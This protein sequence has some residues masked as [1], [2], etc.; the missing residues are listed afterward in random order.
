MK[1]I[2]LFYII[3]LF[4]ISIYL[5]GFNILGNN[6]DPNL[7]QPPKQ[8]WDH[9]SGSMPGEV[10]VITDNSGFDNFDL[11]VD[12]SESHISSS[13]KNPNWYFVAYN[14]N[15][16]YYT[17]NGLD[18]QRNNPF[19]PNQAGDPVTAYDSLGNLYYDNMKSPITGTWNIKSTNGGVS[20][21]SPVSANIG[22]DKN[23]IAADQTNGPYSNYIYGV[24]TPGN[25]VR[26]TD[27]GASYNL[28]FSASNNLPGMMVAVG[29]NTVG[30]NVSGG[31]VYVVTNTG[32]SFAATY[33]FFRS[34]N[35]GQSFDFMSSQN[36][37]NY[38]G[39]AVNGRNSVQ[40]FRTRP[41]PFITA[42]NSFGPNRGRLYL[43]Y[44]SNTP[45]GDGNKPDIFCRY[46]TNHGT[47][48]SSEVRI[49]DDPNTVLHNQW[50]PS[51]WCDKETGR[52]YVQWNDTRDTPTS[53]SALV[54][55]SYSTDGGATFVQNKMISNKKFRINCTTCGG[56]GTPAYLG[57][58]SSITSNSVT[59]MLTWTD[60]RNNNFGSYVGYYPDFALKT[61]SQSISVNSGQNVTFRAIVPA[62]KDY[63]RVVKFTATM[64]T[65]PAAG[66]LN[67][68]FVGKDSVNSFPD[69]VS[70]NV[71]AVGSVTPGRYSIKVIG[72]GPNGT[73]I[74][75]RYVSVLVN[76]SFL[77]VGTNRPGTAEFS[78]NGIVYNQTQQLVFTNGASVN[79]TA[80]SPRVVGATQYVFTNWSNSGDT[81]QTI[82][83]NSNTNLTAFYKTQYRL[84]ITS[85]VGNTFG[86]GVYYDSASSPQIGVLSRVINSGG[87]NYYFRGWTGIGAGSYTSPDSTGL[88]SVITIN[89]ITVPIVETARWTTT[90]GINQLSSLV[91]DKFS[92]YQNYPNPFNPTTNIKFDII[93]SGGVK[94][95]VYNALGKEVNVLLNENLSP[96]TY[97]VDFDGAGFASGIYYYKIVTSE[98]TDVK[99]ML[100]IK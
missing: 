82:V 18:W 96:G 19:F 51:T 35:G 92:L 36:F 59:A 86:G 37:A 94:V 12:F 81:S 97:K 74:H 13:P 20:W 8:Y 46:S 89:N 42:D 24:M 53:D 62:V 33:S 65:L 99:K 22:N 64:D 29:A 43:V 87:T 41:Y 30:G 55:A 70:I 75:S 50:H 3:P 2:T 45:A 61:S 93:K 57:D 77:T 40:N 69:S 39:T 32:N 98:F 16:T 52:L 1:K 79:V 83:I 54:Y 90:V 10:T 67:I 27:G 78:V 31:C 14:T 23:W 4:V 44:S 85:S 63:G 60:F 28:V 7:D 49:N 91:P 26:S 5:S 66:S 25:V 68:S 72:K 58:Y 71:A 76:S 34:T 100:L 80:I 15:A 9:V 84:L 95:I 6:D 88:D 11:G 48:W 47:T 17:L 38:V 21:L 56:G 73:P